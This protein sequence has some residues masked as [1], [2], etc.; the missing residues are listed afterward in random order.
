MAERPVKK[1]K[2]LLP[3]K[4]KDGVVERTEEVDGNAVIIKLCLIKYLLYKSV[5]YY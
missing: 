4:T 3:I 2:S 1:L 5:Y